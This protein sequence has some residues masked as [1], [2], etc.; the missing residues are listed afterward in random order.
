MTEREQAP[1]SGPARTPRRWPIRLLQV[2]V[3]I[4]LLV[5]V[6]RGANGGEAVRL[7]QEAEL[8]WLVVAVVV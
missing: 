1:A 3:A 8:V 5:A 6:W 4:G 2:A 7:L